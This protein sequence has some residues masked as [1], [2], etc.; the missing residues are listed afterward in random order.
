[1]F[2]CNGDR[3]PDVYLAGGINPSGLY[4][5]HSSTGG[6]LEFARVEASST[7]LTSVTGAYPIDIDGDDLVD[8][9]VLAVGENVMLR[10]L[11]DCRFETANEAWGVDGGNEWT[12][13]FSATWEGGAALP[14]L[15][16]GN[17]LADLGQTR[18]ACDDSYLIRPG[19]DGDG[20]GARTALSPGWCTLSVLFSDWDRSGRRDLR[21]TNDRHYY[22]DGQEQLWRME[23]GT[24]PR[25]YTAE[26]GWHTMKIWG[27]GIATQDLTG[28]GLP[29]VFL[30]SQGD[31]KLQTLADGPAQPTYV[32]IALESGANAHR[33]FHRPGHGLSIYRMAHRVSGRE[34]RHLRRPLREQGQCRS[35][36][37]VRRR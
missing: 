22:R 15:A 20:Y 35:P 18:A 19:P 25:L 3:L 5:N 1:M 32:D 10:G 14:T 9:A 28:D 6:P 11:G 29:E 13:A 21:V 30:T 34:Q 36:A 4:V 2:D 31:N 33:P 16:F 37:R 8:L 17:Y 7:D 27:M 23:A 24:A 12:A 26:D